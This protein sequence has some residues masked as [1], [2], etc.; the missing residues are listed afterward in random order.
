MDVSPPWVPIKF[1]ENAVLLTYHP[2]SLGL[3]Q[4]VRLFHPSP[5]I[6]KMGP[7]YF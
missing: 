6:D 3:F 1:D 4:R 2:G 7:D 5:N